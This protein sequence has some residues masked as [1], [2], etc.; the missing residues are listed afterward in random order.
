ME[1]KWLAIGAALTACLFLAAPVFA[2]EIEE[3]KRRIDILSDEVEELRTSG[4]AGT[5]KPDRVKVFGYGEMHLNHRPGDQGVTKIDQ[6]RFVIGIQALLTDWIHLNAEIDFEHAAQELEFE[7]AYLD[8]LIDEKL[9]ARAGVM[10]LPVG[11]L[12]EFH[13]PTLFWSV[14]RPDLQ[15][16][17]IP[18][19]WSGAGAG[20]FGTPIEGLNYRLYVVNAVQSISDGTDQGQFK[21]SSGI[22]S[23]RQQ[24]D[25]TLAENWAVTGRLEYSK[26]Y[27][28][29][30]LGFSFYTGNTTHGIIDEGGQTTLLEGDVKYRWK[31]FE[32]NSTVVNIDISD[33]G[34]IN[35]FAFNQGNADGIVADNIFGWNVQAG[36]HLPQLL[37]MST[38]QDL[39]PFFLYENYDTQDSVPTD[40]AVANCVKDPHNDVEVF[41]AGLSYMPV[42][43]VAL[44]TDWQHRKFGDNTSDDQ[45][46]VG[47]A[48]MY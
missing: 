19:T 42:Q 11:F 27:P 2:A 4:P 20:V 33:A 8:F 6:H 7:L 31:W 10:L 21:G 38:S 35:D 17:V 40:C 41:T 30:Q 22:R 13:E 18:T 23:G 3:L 12:N 48:Y 29:L 45:I 47:I 43:N 5:T 9:N 16:N 37:G 39:I 15:K 14:E 44:K 34:A 28:G 26:L 32:M 1:G 36:V 24:L 46:N 25:E